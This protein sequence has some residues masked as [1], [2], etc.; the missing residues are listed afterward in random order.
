MMFQNLVFCLKHFLNPAESGYN[1]LTRLE[2]ETFLSKFETPND[3][4]E[5]SYF[6]YI[7]QCHLSKQRQNYLK[8]FIACMTVDLI[9]IYNI[10]CKSPKLYNENKCHDVFFFEGSDSIIPDSLTFGYVKVP[11][12]PSFCLSR[13]D[14]RF[15]LEFVRK[16]PFS[17]MFLL[18]NI[19]KI[20]MYSR[21]IDKYRPNKIMSSCEYSYT[22][23][24]LT[25]YCESRGIEHINVMHGEKIFNIRDS[26]CRFTKFYV[27]DE[28]YLWLFCKL[29]ADQSN[30]VV[31]QCK[32]IRLNISKYVLSKEDCFDYTFYLAIEDADTLSKLRQ[33][34]NELQAHGERVILRP[35]PL[36]TCLR[37]LNEYFVTG[38]IE[39]PQEVDLA[40]S[41]ARTTN[42]VSIGSTVL[43]QAFVLHKNIVIDNISNLNRYKWFQDNAYIMFGKHHVLLSDKLIY[44]Q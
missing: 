13:N 17:G 23:S 16:H 34:V 32:A 41:I 43:Y 21:A 18:K 35:H 42:V 6:Q 24:I 22:S 3:D 1:T 2:Q 20:S 27:W 31:E 40:F 19:I 29:K 44:R 14:I 12:N 4:I 36:Y 33:I 38:E 26:F 30:F 5:R 39:I 25:K 28:Y 7:C 10:L 37:L 8:N 15:V 9:L 11:L